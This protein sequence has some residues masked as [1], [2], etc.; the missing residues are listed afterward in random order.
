MAYNKPNLYN[1]NKQTMLDNITATCSTNFLS[2]QPSCGA[3]S[4]NVDQIPEQTCGSDSTG[5]CGVISLPTNGCT[6]NSTSGCSPSSNPGCGGANNYQC[7]AG[8][9]TARCNQLYPSNKFYSFPGT[10]GDDQFISID[11]DPYTNDI[12][13]TAGSSYPVEQ[14]AELCKEL[15]T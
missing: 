13:I 15:Y 9:S 11:L 14:L 6:P 8:S 4:C 2:G 10:E 7:T 1:V 12:K 5:P 3:S